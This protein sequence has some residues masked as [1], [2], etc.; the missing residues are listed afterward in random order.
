MR[1]GIDTHHLL[2]E[3]AG[4]KRV[5]LNLIEQFRKDTGLDVVELCPR[6][7]IKRGST[8]TSKLSGHF[9]RF[10]WVHLQLPWLCW[11]RGIE[12]LLSPEFNTPMFTPCPRAVIAHD[13]H[14]RAQ[15][16][17]TNSLWFYFYYIPFIEFSIR[18]A[19]LVLTV[20]NFAKQQVVSLMGIEQA[21]VRVVHNGVDQIFFNQQDGP[22]KLKDSFPELCGQPYILFV[23]TFEARK[24]IERLIEAFARFKKKHASDAKLAIVGTPATGKFSDRSQKITD[25]ISRENLTNDVIVCGY[26]ADSLLPAIYRNA[27]LLAFPSLQEGFGLPVIE[28]F[29][30]G[31]PVLTSNVCSLPEIGGEAALYVDPFNV[32]DISQRIEQLMLN[33]SLR[34]QLID[35]GRK[36][37][38]MFT[39]ENC[40]RQMISLLE[41][42]V[43]K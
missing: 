10:F 25:M 42:L 3:H 28:G 23:G 37:A 32:D 8:V 16:E 13:A 6:Y 19:N 43:K 15:R 7:S 39:W 36:R 40:A 35:A 34:E 22:D 5:T 27:R 18:R 17:Y 29:A 4:T 12:V 41:S 11:R 33:D 30:S 31:T 9:R 1:L 20:S 14:M 26:V 24:N 2:L 21:K 38:E